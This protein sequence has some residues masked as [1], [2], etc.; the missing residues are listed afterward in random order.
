MVTVNDI[1]RECGVSHT[2]VVRALNETGRIN[3]KTRQRILQKAEELGYRPDLLARVLTKGRS[4]TLGV[5][6]PDLKNQYY[7]IILDSMAGSARLLGYQLSIG[8]HEGDAQIE[9]NLMNTLAGYRADG[10][11]LSCTA[12][13]EAL[14]SFLLSLPMPVVLMGL[15]VFADIASIGIDEEKAAFEITRQMI[16]AGYRHIVFVAPIM[17]HQN[18]IA[19]GHKQRHQG[20]LRAL[21]D[22]AQLALRMISASQDYVGD[23][24]TLVQTLKEPIGI[25][26]SGESYADHLMRH[27]RSL[28]YTAGTHY[29]IAAF[30]NMDVFKQPDGV[31]TTVDNAVEETG[32]LA[33]EMLIRTIEGKDPPKH[34]SVE[35]PFQ[36]IRGTTL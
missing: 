29:G 31:L 19:Q 1:A 7:P 27:L 22:D 17:P 12:P 24:V 28:G 10:I 13:T 26:C 30:D 6:V 2:T 25:L 8:L 3:V 14:H 33:V 4:M 23:I 16:A 21:K 15:N 9:R 35:I 34:N 32:T 18:A 20:V 36:I 5:V 11:I